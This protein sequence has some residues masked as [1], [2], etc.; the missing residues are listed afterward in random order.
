MDITVKELKEKMS[1]EDGFILIDVRE[2]YEHAD[3][4]IG[5]NLIPLGDIPA[6]MGDLEEYKDSEIIVYCRSGRRS[7]N[8]QAF[9]QQNGFKNVRNLIGGML[10]WEDTFGRNK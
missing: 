6:A 10:D 5:G 7:A 8:A 4:N 9:L 1:N 2:S 3:F